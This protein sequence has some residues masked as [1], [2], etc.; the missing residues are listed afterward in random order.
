MAIIDDGEDA[1]TA[2]VD[3]YTRRFSFGADAEGAP[4]CAL[5]W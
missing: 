3:I 1:V 2:S 5:A 4:S